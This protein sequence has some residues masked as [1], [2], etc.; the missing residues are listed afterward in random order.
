MF[1]SK[2]ITLSEMLRLRLVAIGRK[3]SRCNM[4][5]PFLVRVWVR[6]AEVLNFFKDFSVTYL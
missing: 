5:P 2:D 4:N 3:R 6:A 1:I